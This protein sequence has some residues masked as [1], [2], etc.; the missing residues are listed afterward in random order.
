MTS[1]RTNLSIKLFRRQGLVACKS[2]FIGILAFCLIGAERGD[3]QE[4]ELKAAYLLS[5]PKHITWPDS[6]FTDTDAEVVIGVMGKDPIQEVLRKAVEGRTRQGR[7]ITVRKI[8]TDATAEELRACHI[9]YV[10]ESQKGKLDKILAMLAS[11]PI[12]TVS[13][14][15]GFAK[16][17]GIG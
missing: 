2:L 16:D 14:F 6:V 15:D 13:D 7:K 3:V 1:P 11:A 12:L 17:G 8:S 5:L 10:S 9:L 4:Y